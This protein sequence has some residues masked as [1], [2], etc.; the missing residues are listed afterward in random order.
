MKPHYDSL[1]EI[2]NLMPA[3]DY[4]QARL[5]GPD[6]AP[7][8]TVQ[9]VFAFAVVS[10]REMDLDAGPGHVYAQ[11]WIAPLTT[12]E[13]INIQNNCNYDWM[14]TEFREQRMITV[15]ADN[16]M[17]AW[18]MARG[19]VGRDD[20]GVLKFLYSDAETDLIYGEEVTA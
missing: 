1:F 17:E 18:R 11:D 20:E 3:E 14:A 4:W 6:E 7:R 19:S 13:L 10:T 15:Y 9:R 8:L 5:T 12:D 16:Q 2:K